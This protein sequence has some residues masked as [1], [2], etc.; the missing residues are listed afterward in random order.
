MIIIIVQF[1]PVISTSF[2]SYDKVNISLT[3][4]PLLFLLTNIII[5]NYPVI[6][7]FISQDFF[8]PCFQVLYF[9]CKNNVKN[10]LQTLNT[11]VI[12]SFVISK[13]EILT[14]VYRAEV[15]FYNY[16]GEMDFLFVFI[17]ML[18]CIVGYCVIKGSNKQYFNL[19]SVHVILYMS[20]VVNE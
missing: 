16:M 2:P 3:L 6:V 14:D 18:C 10:V 20:N 15:T 4:I 19:M 13:G 1:I 11:F 12:F 8:S 9:R 17:I 7:L 5:I